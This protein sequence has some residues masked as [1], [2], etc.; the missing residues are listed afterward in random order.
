MNEYNI[1]DYGRYSFTIK[2]KR[3]HPIPG[4][5]YI[6]TGFDL[7]GTIVEADERNVII[8]DNDDLIYLVAKKNIRSF[9]AE[10]NEKLPIHEL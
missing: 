3:K 1:G 5:S 7:C 8:Q 9:Q 2:K 10:K 6:I 4:D